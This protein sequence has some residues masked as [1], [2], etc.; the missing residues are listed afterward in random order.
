MPMPMPVRLHCKGSV[1]PQDRELCAVAESGRL[2]GPY[3]HNSIPISMY[4]W[5]HVG[6]GPATN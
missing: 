3:C 4:V 1:V 2:G 5:V 6:R